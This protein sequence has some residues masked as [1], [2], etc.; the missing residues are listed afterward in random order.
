M[1]G[2]LTSVDRSDQR[3]TGKWAPMWLVEI[4]LLE[5]ADRFIVQAKRPFSCFF[6]YLSSRMHGSW[7]PFFQRVW[8]GG[9]ARKQTMIYAADECTRTSRRG[10]KFWEAARSM[11]SSRYGKKDARPLRFGLSSSVLRLGR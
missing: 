7:V 10:R 11:R 6:A 5:L 1:Y 9:R 4:V 8:A 2:T 3:V